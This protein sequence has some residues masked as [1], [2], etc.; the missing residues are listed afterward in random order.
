MN[1][2][3]RK[4]IS[5][6]CTVIFII[7]AAICIICMAVYIIKDSAAT[8]TYEELKQDYI[9]EETIETDLDVPVVEETGNLTADESIEEP[10]PE[11]NPLD[12]YDVPVKTIEWEALKAENEHVYAW[13]TVPGT[14][15]DYP[16]VQHPEELDYYLLHN[17]DGSS[18]HPG[19]IYTQLLNSK[20]WDDPHTVL[21][22]HNMRN[23]SMFAGLHQYEDSLFFE[24]NPYVYIYSEDCVR[25]YQIFAAYE[26][27]NAHLLLLFDSKDPENFE[28]Y[29]ED[30]FKSE[31]F[32]DNINREI[33][34]TAENKI[35]TLSTCVTNKP[36]NRFLVQAVLVAEGS[37]EQ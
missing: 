32:N 22:G 13:L 34:L 9:K 27:T 4:Q 19:C 37:T 36:D 14:A 6:V 17:F 16:V 3:K 18:G 8:D 35:I 33:E 23:G 24:E 10:E 31:G 2:S 30:I 1:K 11:V 28:K 12:A 5:A 29:L 20:E 21:Y 15:I 26:F 7:A 25:V